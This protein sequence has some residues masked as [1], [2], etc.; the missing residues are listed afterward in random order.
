MSTLADEMKAHALEAQRFSRKHLVLELDFSEAS[1]QLLEGQADS[2]GFALR[3]GCT[4]ENIEMLTR[5]WGAYVG[6]ALRKATAAEWVLETAGQ[7]RRIGLKGPNGVV[8]PHEQVHKRLTGVKNPSLLSFF[9]Q[10]CA[11]LK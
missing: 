5:I 11:Q 9:Q 7:V 1:I 4:P 8:H 3:G 2:I 10:C 6:E